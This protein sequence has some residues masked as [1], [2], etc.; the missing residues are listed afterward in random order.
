MK[1]R[2]VFGLGL[3]KTGT[4]SL[5]EA[6]NQL[7]IATLHYPC[8]AQTYAELRSGVY[9]LSILREYQALVDIPVAPYYAQL[10]QHYPG[11]KFILT[12][13]SIDAWLR[14]IELHW[15]LMMVWWENYPEFKRF[16]EF[17]SA[18]VYGSIAFNRE[19]FAFAY[20]TH[21]HNVQRYFA[22]RPDDLL[23]IDIC[24]G[25]GWAELCPFLGLPQ[26]ST[27]F[28]HANEWMHLLL[29]ATQDLARLV[30]PGSTLILV[31]Q[32]AFG[33]GVAA[34]RRTLPFLERDGGYWGP[35]PDD[36]SA[37]REFERLRAAG[38]EWIVFGWPAFWW[39]DHYANFR[40]SLRSRFRCALAND[41]LIAFDLR[42]QGSGVGD[43][44]TEG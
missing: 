22:D 24:G 21:V 35:P 4:S 18:A 1:H 25:Q 13:R 11:S 29:L 31:D 3:S 44:R 6:L 32:N 16:T 5:G 41:R 8:D 7:G 28:P 20:E 19:R 40:S 37:I 23:V 36:A 10:D 15:Q 2:K 14:S 34:D 17:I 33:P 9:Q 39:L 26:P 27:P 42:D 12:T 38:A 43:Q 30:P